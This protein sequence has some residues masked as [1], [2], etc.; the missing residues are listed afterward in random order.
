LESGVVAVYGA[1]VWCDCDQVLSADE[2]FGAGVGEGVE[3]VGERDRVEF[4]GGL[5]DY[6]DVD[7]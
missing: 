5:Y 7:Y 1:D 3:F 6:G 4:E 2:L